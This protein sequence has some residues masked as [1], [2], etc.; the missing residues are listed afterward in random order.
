MA[1][2][3]LKF[4]VNTPEKPEVLAITIELGWDDPDLTVGKLLRVWR[5][6]DQHTEEGNAANV[7]PALLDR[8]VGVTGF[9]QAMANVGWLVIEEGGISLPN[10]DRHNGKTAKNRSL[11]AKRVANHKSNAKANAQGNGASVTNALPR[12]EKRREDIN[13]THPLPFP[14]VRETIERCA[15]QARKDSAEV[16]HNDL[17]TSLR[18]EGWELTAEHQVEDRGDGRQGRVDILV[19]SPAVVG[20]ELDRLSIREKSVFKLSQ[21]EGYRVAVL[22]EAAEH[23]GHADLD[24]VIC[25]GTAKVR[26]RKP[27]IQLK[28]FIENCRAAGEN[29]I[30]GYQPL[31]NYVEETGLPMEFVQLAWDEFKRNFGPGGKDEARMQADW[32]RHFLNFVE[33]NY[34]RLWAA[35]VGENGNE[36]FLTTQGLQAQALHRRREGVAA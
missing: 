24:A 4:E 11:T 30:S 25:C 23:D 3:W 16:F 1:G 21:V 29:A 12:E 27:R 35:R 7:T 2:D 10:F 34:L 33:K 28:T 31:L 18:E 14:A 26:E 13:T 17:M 9:C 36:Y 15:K 5:W 19:T 22:R 8:I 20:I 32:R 6:F